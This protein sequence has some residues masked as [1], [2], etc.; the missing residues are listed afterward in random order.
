MNTFVPVDKKS[1]KNFVSHI[2]FKWVFRK[3]HDFIGYFNVQLDHFKGKR[4]ANLQF[5]RVNL[6]VIKFDL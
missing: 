3:L 6:R 5:R 4:R 1:G 2:S